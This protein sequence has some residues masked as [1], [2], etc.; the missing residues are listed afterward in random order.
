MAMQGRLSS[1]V[2]KGATS[3]EVEPIGAADNFIITGGDAYIG[4]DKFTYTAYTL[5]TTSFTLT[6]CEGIDFSHDAEEDISPIYGPHFK[7][8]AP[9][10]LKTTSNDPDGF[11]EALFEI[12]ENGLFKT[13]KDASIDVTENIDPTRAESLFL[14]YICSNLGV[15]SNEDVSDGVLR[16]L[17]MQAANVLKARGTINAFK[18][19]VYHTLEYVVD[20]E[21]KRANINAVW[22]DKNFRWYIPPTEVELND[23]SVSYWKFTEGSGTSVANEVSGGTALTLANAAMWD[24]DSMFR[25]DLSLEIGAVHTY[26]ESSATAISA[27]NLHGK[28]AWSIKLNMKPA[29]GGAT[30]QTVM[31]KGTMIVITRPN[32]TDLTVTMSDGVSTVSNTFTDCIVENQWNYVSILFNRPTMSLVVDGEIIDSVIT[33]DLDTVDMG[34][35][36]VLGD[37]TGVQPFLGKIDTVMISSG[38]E[39]PMESIQYFAHIDILRR[40]GTDI[41]R[42]FYYFDNNEN[43]GHITITILNG[44]GDADKLEFFNYLVE[45]WLA[46]S[47]YDVIDVAHLPIEMQLGMWL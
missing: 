32:A 36:W 30:P 42:N 26:A 38:V 19:M 13:I 29:T 47:N 9:V 35:P 16:S 33:F 6:S 37:K 41:D 11:W 10:P 40:Y 23:R 1:R 17:A 15:E 25:K 5:G 43:D 14:K 4:T 7:K 12:L 18:F 8:L 39:Y 45:E 31:Y 3:V 27:G 34:D 28:K 24:A 22:N 44:D 21:V 2:L 46:V 20:V